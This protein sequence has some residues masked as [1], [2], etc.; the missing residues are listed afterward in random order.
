MPLGRLV[1]HPKILVAGLNTTKVSSRS[2][3]YL[4]LSSRFDLC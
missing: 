3:P 1:Y 4:S 2:A